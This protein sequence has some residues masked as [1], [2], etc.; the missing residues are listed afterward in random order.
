[1]S[2][3]A[4]KALDLN[5]QFKRNC[6]NNLLSVIS[7]RTV[8][9]QCC[10]CPIALCSG[11]STAPLI[12][13]SSTAKQNCNYKA[14][15]S[16]QGYRRTDSGGTSMPR[17]PRPR[18]MPSASARIS[19]KLRRPYVKRG[20]KRERAQ[21]Q[22]ACAY[23]FGGHID[24]EIPP[25]KDDPVGLREDL[26]EVLEAL[27]GTRTQREACVVAKEGQGREVLTGDCD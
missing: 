2:L 1:M 11:Q 21:K 7:S 23:L 13:R 26:V 8:P 5:H 27:P 22:T 14:K 17:F 10:P 19:S 15:E 20:G 6:K 3:L 24:T 25:R 16:S 18:M 4:P 9:K 12:R